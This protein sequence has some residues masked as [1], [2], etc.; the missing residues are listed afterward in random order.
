M[1]PIP[2][3]IQD[4]IV[5]FL[6]NESAVT[7]RVGFWMTGTPVTQQG[8]VLDIPGLTIEVAR[9]CS[10][11]RSS[12]LLIVMTMVL[13]HLFLG[14]WWRKSLL[15]AATIPLMVA[16]NGLRIF[17]IAELG[18][19]GDPGF[20]DG[21]L[22]HHGGIVFLA[23]AVAIVIVLIWILRRSETSQSRVISEPPW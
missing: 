19:R 14:S 4:W 16:K 1:V 6:Q 13:A 17:V 3:V 21:K 7:A 20:L 5:A 18:T 10:S 2:A 11:I 12:L 22:H 23:I 8:T 9:E 15:V